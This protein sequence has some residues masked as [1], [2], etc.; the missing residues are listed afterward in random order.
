MKSGMILHAEDDANDAFLFQRALSRAG[1]ENPLTH[2]PD[3]ETAVRYLTGVG[4]YSD[5]EKH[6]FPCLL[7]TD[8][9]MPVVSGF[10]LL[11]QV[12]GMLE[13]KQLRAIVLTAS[14]ADQ[15]KERCRQLGAH[16]YFVKP[17]D[18]KGLIALAGQIKESW[19]LPPTQPA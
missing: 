10:D 19:I 9:K 11:E 5:R 4:P 16:D 15:D 18:M 1:V 6:P 14:V 12:K 3:G 2:V 13:T 7:I 17:S 8:L